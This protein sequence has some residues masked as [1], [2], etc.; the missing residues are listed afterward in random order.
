[1]AI[2]IDNDNDEELPLLHTNNIKIKFESREDKSQPKSVEKR[3]VGIV[4]GKVRLFKRIKR[5]ERMI[6]RLSSVWKE[7]FRF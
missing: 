5:R 3:Q 2:A 6:I 7:K 1:M 4:T